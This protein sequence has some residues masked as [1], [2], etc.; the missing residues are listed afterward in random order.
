MKTP[1]GRFDLHAAQVQR[2]RRA[3]KK[4]KEL[5]LFNI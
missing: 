2:E 3:D 1:S 5:K 4:K